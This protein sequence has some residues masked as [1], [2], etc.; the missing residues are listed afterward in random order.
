MRH[1]SA[2]L[3]KIAVALLLFM[4]PSISYAGTAKLSEFVLLHTEATI[5]ASSSYVKMKD[6]TLDQLKVAVAT[7]VSGDYVTVK[8]G[9]LTLYDGN[10]RIYL[11]RKK[12][13]P[14][15]MV[16]TY[17]TVTTATVKYY[18]D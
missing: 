5:L 18:D 7:P 6:Y 15:T 14:A 16:I 11:L 2:Q 4:L 13:A 10:T 12:G 1:R 17:D 8:T 3:A 9:T